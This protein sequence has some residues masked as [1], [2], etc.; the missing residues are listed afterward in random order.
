MSAYGKLVL[1]KV[2][3]TVIWVVLSAVIYYLLYAVIAD[4]IGRW[5]WMGLGLVGLEIIALLLFRMSCPLTVGWLEVPRTDGARSD[6][7]PRQGVAK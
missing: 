7:S 3:H 5:F 6:R 4:R 2:L 1:I